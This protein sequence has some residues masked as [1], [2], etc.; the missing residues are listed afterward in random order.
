MRNDFRESDQLETLETNF[1]NVFSSDPTDPTD[2]SR[3]VDRKNDLRTRNKFFRSGSVDTVGSPLVN[4][5]EIAIQAGKDVG[6]TPGSTWRHAQ[7]HAKPR[8]LPHGVLAP[9]GVERRPW[10]T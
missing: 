9:A 8:T 5:G 7:T 2:P 6:K 4:V 3:R 1:V 10:S